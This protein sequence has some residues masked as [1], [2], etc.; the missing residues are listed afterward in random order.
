[1]IVSRIS[2]AAEKVASRLLLISV[3]FVC[4][5]AAYADGWR[6]IK[7]EAGIQISVRNVGS[8]REVRAATMIRSTPRAALALL[9]Q[10]D[11]GPEWIKYCKAA[12]MIELN[13][14]GDFVAY[15][16]TTLPFPLQDRDAVLRMHVDE[17][18]DRIRISFEADPDRIPKDPRYVRITDMVGA[19]SFIQKAEGMLVIYEFSTDP[20]GLFPDWFVNLALGHQPFHTLS[21]LRRILEA[22]RM[23][24]E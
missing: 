13:A 1:M 10:I 18:P 11:R 5:S 23:A 7:N 14:S 16:A 12:R 21:N 24:Y 2:R 17:L 9:R 8:R 4:A 6:S 15:S 22:Q 19:W 3:C 20:G